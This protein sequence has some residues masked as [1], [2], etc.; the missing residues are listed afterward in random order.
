M[1][2]LES[3]DSW[4]KVRETTIRGDRER[5]NRIVNT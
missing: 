5:L 3:E 2:S 1:Q 4:R